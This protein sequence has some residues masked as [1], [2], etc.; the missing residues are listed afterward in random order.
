MS[1]ALA[2]RLYRIGTET[3]WFDE[4]IT[5][6]GLH[7]DNPMDFFRNEATRDP[8]SVPFYYACAYIWYHLGFT[9][10]LAMRLLSVIGGMAV[11]AGLYAFGRKLFGHIGGLTAALCVAC[12]KLHVYE[13]Q[14]IR[15]Y[16]FTLSLALLAMFSL[17]KAAIE[18]DRRWWPVNVAANVLLSYT[19]LLGTVLLFGEGVYLLL[20]RPRQIK[21][22]AL[23]TLA[24]L[25]FLA[26]IPLWVRLITTA[27]FTHETEWI[28]RSF[29][30]RLF[31]AYFYVFAGSKLDAPDFVR[32][33]PLGSVPIPQILGTAMLLAGVAF[34]GYSLWVWRKKNNCLPGF[35]PASALFVLVWLFVPPAALYIVG[36]FQPCFLERYV[37]YSSLALYLCVGGAVAALPSRAAQY[38][39]FAALALIFAGNTVDMARPLRYDVGAAGAVLRDEY[40]GGEHVYTWHEDLQIP[41]RFY[42]GV[43]ENMLVGADDYAKQAVAEADSGHRTWICFHEVPHRFEHGD[44]EHEIAEHPSIS[45]ERWSYGGRWN[46]FLYRLDPAHPATDEQ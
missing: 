43:P 12:V 27:N 29:K 37:L 5:Y 41:L 34:A 33:L 25:P 4:C 22:I 11:V 9:T 6:M 35:Q 36:K 7:F 42:G 44:V 21:S 10:V 46:M 3:I 8:S 13:S 38:A 19:H 15:N 30:Q 31:D 23:W 26:L 20:T 18:N 16:T 2:M 24:H 40:A 17:Y 39:A 28:P 14:E 45:M 32:A 1:L